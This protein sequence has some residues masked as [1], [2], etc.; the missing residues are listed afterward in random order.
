MN[1]DKETKKDFSKLFTSFVKEYRRNLL[2]MYP[3]DPD[4]KATLAEANL[5][6]S[7]FV[8]S[9]REDAFKDAVAW[10]EYSVKGQRVESEKEG[11]DGGNMDGFLLDS[12]GKRILLIESKRMKL[13][14]N[15]TLESDNGSLVSDLA[16]EI[17]VANSDVFPSRIWASSSSEGFE[18]LG[19]KYRDYR[20]FGVALASLWVKKVVLAEERVKDLFLKYIKDNLANEGI[21]QELVNLELPLVTTESAFCDVKDLSDLFP[22]LKDGPWSYYLILFAWEINRPGFAY[23]D[24][25]LLPRNITKIQMHEE[26]SDNIYPLLGTLQSEGEIFCFKK[27]SGSD[28][29]YIWPLAYRNQ[30]ANLSSRERNARQVWIELNGPGNDVALVVVD[31]RSKI[32]TVPKEWI[33]QDAKKPYSLGKNARN[34]AYFV[35]GS[36]SDFAT[37]LGLEKMLGNLRKALGGLDQLEFE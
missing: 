26:K 15:Y 36:R 4:S 13:Q 2:G 34:G 23:H 30:M 31:T 22:K 27:N 24:Y 5:T 7:F 32:K 29:A 12:K 10:N 6:T 19:S 25:P 18:L 33:I 21:D 3:C 17:N 16:R 11:S 1:M 35:I 20:T 37:E 9:K 8:A 28:W 14:K